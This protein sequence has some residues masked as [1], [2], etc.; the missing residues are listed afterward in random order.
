MPVPAKEL[1]LLLRSTYTFGGPSKPDM[2]APVG[3]AGDNWS[4]PT[5]VDRWHE[6][7]QA[8]ARDAFLGRLRL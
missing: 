1:S 4:R 8:R 5:V 6:V 2:V 7:Q 3:G